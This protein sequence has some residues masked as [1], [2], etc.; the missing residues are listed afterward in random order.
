MSVHSTC[1]PQFETRDVKHIKI[2]TNK[3]SKTSLSSGLKFKEV[4]STKNML[5]SN[6]ST[7]RECNKYNYMFIKQAE[8][9]FILGLLFRFY[10][11]SPH[12]FFQKKP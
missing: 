10:I 3:I 7:T 8:G 2:N 9:T 6:E 12:E 5:N 4:P 11:S 1:S